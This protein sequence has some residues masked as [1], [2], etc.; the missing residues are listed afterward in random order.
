MSRRSHW[1]PLP[2]RVMRRP[3]DWTMGRRPHRPAASVRWLSR[4]RCGRAVRSDPDARSRSGDRVL[5][6]SCTILSAKRWITETS[7]PSRKSFTSALSDRL[8]L[9][10]IFGSRG[11]RMQA[12][13]QRR[14]CPSLSKRLDGSPGRCKRIARKIDAIEVAIVLAAVLKM[15]VDLQA[16]AEHIRGRPG[17]RALAMDVEHEPPDRHRR[18]PAIVDHLVPVLIPQLG[19]IHPERGQDIERMARRHR[20]LRQREPQ[21]DGLRLA[22]APAQVVRPRA[23][24][25]KRACRSR[26]ALHDRRY[27]R[28]S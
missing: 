5:S 15:I 11:E 26:R 17:R 12:L 20:T 9:S 23:D 1:L 27:R 7:S 28:R 6:E 18:I 21:L 4:R 24:R 10:S 25:D 19:H 13:Q 2:R 3:P 22:V 8:S 16:R 14:R